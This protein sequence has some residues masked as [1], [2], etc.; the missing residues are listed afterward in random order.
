[1]RR[2]VFHAE[3]TEDLAGMA[4][5]AGQLMINASASL[6]QADL[7]LADVVLARGEE[8]PVRHREVQQRC[9][10]LFARHAPVATDLRTLVA[11]L[12]A[13][14]DLRRMGHL[15]QHIARITRF[16]HPHPAVPGGAR[17]VIAR[18]SLLAGG[19]ADQAAIAL[20]KRDP[21]SIKR[22]ARADD[23]V[24]ALRGELFRIVFATNW[25]HGVQPAVHA[26][27]IGRY[28]ERFADH[29]VAIAGRACYLAT[30]RLPELLPLPR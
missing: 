1:M 11:A 30:G 18:M 9:G 7:A 23:E 16:A 8:L 28:C 20:E 4:R 19:L 6:F 14:S 26:A 27:L 3:L 5:L 12:R 21:G 10:T 25:S 15:A 2:A 22:L 24:D 13:G 17:P 29:A